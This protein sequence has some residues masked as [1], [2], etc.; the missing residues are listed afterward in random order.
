[1]T[2]F[3]LFTFAHTGPSTSSHI[4]SSSRHK[5]STTVNIFVGGAQVQA[6]TSK[7]QN[8]V[9][10]RAKKK[11]NQTRTQRAKTYFQRK[12]AEHA[13]RRN[14]PEEAIEIADSSDVAVISVSSEDS[15]SN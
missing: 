14:Q 2:F 13:V 8:S 15:S 12:R 7:D 1:M 10:L 9:S 3:L 6:G 11:R 5:S 4:P